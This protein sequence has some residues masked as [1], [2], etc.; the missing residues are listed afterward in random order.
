[1]LDDHVCVFFGYTSLIFTHFLQYLPLSC[2]IFFLNCRYKTFPK[3]ARYANSFS[4]LWSCCFTFLLLSFKIQMFSFLMNF[5]LS[6]ISCFCVTTRKT[7]LNPRSQRFTPIFSLK[8]FIVLA[9]TFRSLIHFELNF[10]D[11][12]RKGSRIILY[13]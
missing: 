10:L 8:G 1:M 7:L 6:F 3:S 12:R 9:L 4:I 2:K 11:R 5:S 13:M